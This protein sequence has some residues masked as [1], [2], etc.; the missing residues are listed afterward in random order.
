MV[1]PPLYRTHRE[2]VVEEVL[3]LL[4]SFSDFLSFKQL[5]LHHKA[6][7][8]SPYISPPPLMLSLSL[9]L[10][11]RQRKGELWTLEA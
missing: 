5:M 6:V 10:S 1:S 7:S 3:D 8:P 11:S 4:L 2:E 9:S